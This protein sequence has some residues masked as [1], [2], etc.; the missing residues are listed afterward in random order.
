MVL[1]SPV[2]SVR[3]ASLCSFGVER[4][5]KMSALSDI[6][7]LFLFHVLFCAVCSLCEL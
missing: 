2:P 3:L 7:S 5:A 4:L 1:L 6:V